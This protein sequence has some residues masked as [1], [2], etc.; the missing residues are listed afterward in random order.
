MK[1]G[2][3]Q[4]DAVRRELQPRYGDYPDM[5]VN[6]LAGAAD[7]VPSFQVIDCKAMAY[8]PPTEC[9]G[10]V[11]T[12]SGHS[13]YEDLPWITQLA[14]FCER[15]L[16]SERKL[17]GVCF[18]HQL[19]A[20]FFGGRTERVGWAV[21]VHRSEVV[22][23]SAN[24]GAAAGSA[25]AWMR[26]W[27]Q[28]IALLSSHQDQVVALPAGGRPILRNDFCPNAGYVIG[29]Q[30]LT[31][32]GH[33]EFSKPYAQSLMMLRRELLGEA[34]FERGIESLSD[35]THANEVATWM[36]NFIEGSA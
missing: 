28:E 2:I 33:P 17:I 21:G 13:V 23:V 35:A 26:P 8:P 22:G 36:L 27:L 31:V 10:Y 3:L 34:T 29:D 1:I 11:I 19:L 5:F 24:A 16:A 18:G 14:R 20:H 6:L 30:V 7:E 4:T 25:D 12:G 32:Q 15:A 9:D